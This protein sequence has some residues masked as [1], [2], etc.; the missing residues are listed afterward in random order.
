MP[1][2]VKARLSEKNFCPVLKE[3]TL[4]VESQY[5]N[6]KESDQSNVPSQEAL[7]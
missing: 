4:R 2:V 1:D 3:N 5:A 7:I 6:P